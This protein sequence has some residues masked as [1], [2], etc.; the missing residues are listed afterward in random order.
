MSLGG[1]FADVVGHREAHSRRAHHARE[2]RRAPPDAASSKPR[3]R[4]RMAGLR[5]RRRERHRAGGE[6]LGP[7]RSCSTASRWARSTGT[8]TSRPSQGRTAGLD[9]MISAP[10][11]AHGAAGHRRA[12]RAGAGRPGGRDDR[13]E[14]GA[15]RLRRGPSRRDRPHGAGGAAARAH[16]ARHPSRQR[17]AGDARDQ[18]RRAPAGRADRHDRRGR[19][20]D[21]ADSPRARDDR[22]PGQAVH[23]RQRHHDLRGRRPVATP[24][25]SSPPS[26][27]RRTRRACTPT[28]SGP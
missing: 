18:P 21:R 26:G 25:S 14:A 11:A 9:V 24:R 23:D 27:R 3:R 10:S 17:R 6:D 13:G 2:L 5:V 19:E 20:G 28:S 12:R 1:E 4:A 16:Q 8:S 7:S 15:R 22:R